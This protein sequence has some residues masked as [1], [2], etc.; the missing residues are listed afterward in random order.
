[1]REKRAKLTQRPLSDERPKTLDPA[2]APG[3]NVRR[4]L[5]E[6][7]LRDL[8][9]FPRPSRMIANIFDDQKRGEVALEVNC[10]LEFG[11]ESNAAMSGKADLL[12]KLAK[13]RF[14]GALARIAAP[15][16]NTPAGR[17]PKLYEHELAVSGEGERM[18]AESPRPANEPGDAQ[19]PMG[20][21][22]GDPEESVPS[23]A[24]G[25]STPPSDAPTLSSV[26]GGT[27]TG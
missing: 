16:G 1:M 6:R 22:E 10:F 12:P 21:G 8:F 17:V 27:T 24:Q 7:E 20:R 25:R 3:R 2:Q 14:F 11:G 19:Q 5:I 23:A 15:A 4:Q 13:C 18:G 9:H 26:S